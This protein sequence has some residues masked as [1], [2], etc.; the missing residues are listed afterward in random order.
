VSSTGL[1]AGFAFCAGLGGALQV[2]AQSRLGDRVGSIEALTC[3][4]IVS[5]VCATAVLLLARGGFG[6]VG[7]GFTGPSWQLLG[8]VMSAVIV[9]SITVAGPRIGTVATTAMLI[10]GQFVLATAIDRFGWFGF[11]RVAVSWQRV[12][13]V[14]L[15][16]AG[17]VLTLKR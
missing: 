2:A 12:L 7:S 4:A 3:A 17:A 10:S 1:A 16:A 11:E 8:G 9:L 5:A 6:R 15:L 14:A 13:G